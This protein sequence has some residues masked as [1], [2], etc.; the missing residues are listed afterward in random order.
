MLDISKKSEL[1]FFPA[2]FF[3]RFD[4]THQSWTNTLKYL[5]IHYSKTTA[6]L[7]EVMIRNF[8]GKHQT[9]RE[10]ADTSET[11]LYV[12]I[13]EFRRISLFSTGRPF[14]SVCLG[15]LF[16]MVSFFSLILFTASNRDGTSINLLETVFST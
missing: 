2:F 10:H 16:E 9:E 1:F 8:K 5:F 4:I 7:K 14:S 6:K 11:M 13:C 3:L 12:L 15:H